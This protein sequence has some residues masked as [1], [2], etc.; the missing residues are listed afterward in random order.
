MGIDWS[1]VGLKKLELSYMNRLDKTSVTEN[2]PNMGS[3][4][5]MT[6][7]MTIQNYGKFGVFL[8]IPDIQNLHSLYFNLLYLT[9]CS[10]YNTLSNAKFWENFWNIISSTMWRHGLPL[11]K[12]SQLPPLLSVNEPYFKTITGFLYS[13]VH[14]FISK[15][16]KAWWVLFFPFSSF[17]PFLFNQCQGMTTMFPWVWNKVERRCQGNLTSTLIISWPFVAAKV[18]FSW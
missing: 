16:S 11:W 12:E 15:S 10:Q 2:F 6:E 8:N 4:I 7:A 5:R 17:L 3:S 9:C 18:D 1:G 14:D 13:K